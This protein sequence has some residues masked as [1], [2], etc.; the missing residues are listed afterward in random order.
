MRE[1]ADEGAVV[2]AEERDV[3][4]EA[5]AIGWVAVAGCRG[6]SWGYGVCEDWD[7][8]EGDEE[9][10]EMERGHAEL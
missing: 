1:G 6:C 2:G 8:E 9:R 5:G 7:G 10:E 4:V 3:G